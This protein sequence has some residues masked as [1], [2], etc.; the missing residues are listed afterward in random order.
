[1]LQIEGFQTNSKEADINFSNN[2]LIYFTA[3]NLVH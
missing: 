1:M 2:S 3:D